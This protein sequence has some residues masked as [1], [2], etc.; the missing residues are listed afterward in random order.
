M[1][2]KF[3]KIEEIQKEPLTNPLKDIEYTISN[4][5]FNSMFAIYFYSKMAVHEFISGKKPRIPVEL[6]V[7]FLKAVSAA[8]IY[9]RDPS[10]FWINKYENFVKPE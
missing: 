3:F 4:V 5:D 10:T 7:K 1:N 9:K 6:A 2:D 8:G